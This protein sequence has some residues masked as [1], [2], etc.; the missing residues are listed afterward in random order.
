M[1]YFNYHATAKRLIRENKLRD[2]YIAERYR[3]IAPALVL[4]FDDEKHPIMP[5]RRE[6]WEEYE[7]LLRD[8]EKAKRCAHKKEKEGI[9]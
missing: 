7:E 8:Y 1:P 3:R 2:Y 9:E 5:I 6:R 4:L